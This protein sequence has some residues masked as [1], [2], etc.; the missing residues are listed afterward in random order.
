MMIES[1]QHADGLINCV[2]KATG[3]DLSSH[4]ETIAREVYDEGHFEGNNDITVTLGEN[5]I[6][7]IQ[8]DHWDQHMDE[9]E[10][11][12]TWEDMACDVPNG[13]LWFIK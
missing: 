1:Y 3:I 4:R 7:V 11:R 2:K 8:E 12:P 5:T 10:D 13:Y 6:R 9:D